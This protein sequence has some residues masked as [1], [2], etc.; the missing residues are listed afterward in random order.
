MIRTPIHLNL[1]PVVKVVVDLAQKNDNQVFI[2]I[3]PGKDKLGLALVDRSGRL[4]EKKIVKPEETKSYLQDMTNKYDIKKIIVG[5]GTHSGKIKK[6][7][8]EMDL[9]PLLV[10]VDEKGSTEKAERL[11]FKDNPPQGLRKIL[12][13]FVSWSPSQPVDDYAALV[14]VKEYLRNN[15][16]LES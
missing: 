13:L 9:A 16:L 12:A 10:M 4:I 2:G 14:L 3:D 8:I 15:E 7:I 1:I 11:Y 6:L 5:D